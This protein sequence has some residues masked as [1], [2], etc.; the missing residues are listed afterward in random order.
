MD[1]RVERRKKEKDIPQSHGNDRSDASPGQRGKR[2]NR[3]ATHDREGERIPPWN[4]RE[5][6]RTPPSTPPGPR[7]TGRAGSHRSERD[8]AS[9]P[10]METRTVR[11][12]WGMDRPSI[13][14]HPDNVVGRRTGS[15]HPSSI[16][17]GGTQEQSRPH[18]ITRVEPKAPTGGKGRTEGS[19]PTLPTTPIQNRIHPLTRRPSRTHEKTKS[20]AMHQKKKRNRSILSTCTEYRA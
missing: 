9:P 20:N 10:P 6:F 18:T 16:P 1:P 4:E 7:T 12:T 14:T 8:V 17:Y 19:N 2:T 5:T 15:T 11:H 3:K 13:K